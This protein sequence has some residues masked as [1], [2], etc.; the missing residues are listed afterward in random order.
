MQPTAA[1]PPTDQDDRLG[2]AIEAYLALLETGAAPDRNEFAR[3]YPECEADLKEALEGLEVVAGLVGSST[4]PGGPGRSLEAGRRIA[5][6]RIVQELGRGGMGVV[7]EAVHVDLDRPVALK[8]LA[9]HSAPD[10]LSQQRF[11]NEA[12]TAA[13]LHHTHIVPVFD[14]GQVGGLCYY[15]MQRIEGTGLDRI[16]KA[17]RRERT[18]G[19]SSPSGMLSWSRWRTRGQTRTAGIETGNGIDPTASWSGLGSQGLGGPGS[20]SGTGMARARPE[21]TPPSPEPVFQPPRGAAY[22]QWTAR[23][24]RLAAEALAHAHRRGVVHRDIKPSNLLVDDKGVPW[25]ADFGLALRV[26]EPSVAQSDSTQGTPR[27]M[28]PEQSRGEALDGR[29]DVYSLGATLYELLT[30]RPPFEG[31]T[32]AELA[33]QIQN[34]EVVPPRKIDPRIPRD[35]ETVVM[36]AMAKSASDRYASAQELADDLGRFLRLEPIQARHISA[37]ERGWRL[38]RRHPAISAVV[39]TSSA[40]ILAVATYA[41]LRVLEERN[42]AVKAR[43]ITQSALETARTAMEAQK[44]ALGRQL[45]REVTLLRLSRLPDRRSRGMERIREAVETGPDQELAA[46]LR[47]EAVEILSSRDLVTQSRLPTG[48]IWSLTFTS[49]G[50]RL[51]TLN[52]EGTSIRTWCPIE[53]EVKSEWDLREGEEEAANSGM[54][55]GGLMMRMGNGLVPAGPFLAA[56]VRDGQAIRLFDVETGSRHED[57]EME[58]DRIVVSLVGSETGNRLVTVEVVRDREEGPRGPMQPLYQLRLWDTSIPNEQPIATLALPE[59]AENRPRLSFPLVSLSPDSS[60]IA[61]GSFLNSRVEILDGLD[62][63]FVQAIDTQC[64][65]SALAL[66]RGGMLAVAGS[67][68]ARIW[69]LNRDTAPASLTPN[70]AFVSSVRF[71]PD[72][73]LLAISGSGQGIELWDLA[74]NSLFATAPTQGMMRDITFSADGRLLAAKGEMVTV[75]SLEESV[76]RTRQT[77]LETSP[78]GLF[79]ARDGQLILLSDRE[80]P[81]QVWDAAAGSARGAMSDVR[82]PAV[83]QLASGRMLYCDGEAISLLDRLES[84]PV[85]VARL[86]SG[87][88]VERGRGRPGPGPGPNGLGGG[89]PGGPGG[90]PPRLEGAG[91]PPPPPPDRGPGSREGRLRRGNLVKN[92]FA[93]RSVDAAIIPRWGEIYLWRGTDPHRVVRLAI[94]PAARSFELL[95]FATVGSARLVIPGA[96]RVM[97]WRGIALSSDGRRLYALTQDQSVR[98][99]EIGEEGEVTE[100]PWRGLPEAN[101]LALSPDD[102]LLILGVRGGGVAV[103]ATDRGEVTQALSLPNEAGEGAGEAVSMVFHPRESELAI[104]MRDGT[105]RLMDREVDQPSRMRVTLRLPASS[106]RAAPLCF[107]EKGQHLAVAGDRRVDV[108]DLNA[109]QRELEMVGLGW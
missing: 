97:F 86:P 108:W 98:A 18:G 81:P 59:E 13:G 89:G 79:F 16:I 32:S 50:K 8:I 99:F 104:G 71:S 74:S 64:E 48:P 1:T 3:R 11:L 76:G 93:A 22:F 21:S 51:A 95:E 47:D 49:E 19:V 73:S 4:G 80:G 43:Q 17:M 106:N 67:G 85:E 58:A 37:V 63:R 35:L 31:R 34:E 9:T 107:D 28:S 40:V 52:T 82:S 46:K 78:A 66:G 61:V 5:G 45:W 88:E 27:Y 103:I 6:Y 12:K 77:G 42:Q 41:H 29:T 23:L 55:R 57:I 69:D 39:L 70:Q 25:V 44:A 84:T 15:A 53:G 65:T 105:I 38:M 83:A 72:G 36:K 20:M 33:V 7:Y 10:S 100:L 75:W 26:T 60:R 62:G 102:S 87:Q 30:L 24:G 14:V 101:C 54:G 91:A 2:E 92:I 94:P 109:V 56:I 90:P 96:D 68:S